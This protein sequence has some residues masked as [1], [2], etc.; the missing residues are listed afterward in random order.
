MEIYFDQEDPDQGPKIN[1]ENGRKKKSQ[2]DTA[3]MS[4][5]TLDPAQIP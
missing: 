1:P 2:R 3:F 4:G 5:N